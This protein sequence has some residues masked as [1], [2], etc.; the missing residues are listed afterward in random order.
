M[1]SLEERSWDGAVE[2]QLAEYLNSTENMFAIPDSS[3]D[4]AILDCDKSEPY[5]S[6]Q[7]KEGQF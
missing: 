1:P 6:L 2:E 3:S 4:W 7:N 5:D